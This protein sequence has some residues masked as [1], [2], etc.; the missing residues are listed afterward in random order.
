MG[1]AE[2]YRVLIHFTEFY[3]VLPCS[4]KLTATGHRALNET[5]K[6][7]TSATV[8]KFQKTCIIC[9]KK[10]TTRKN[11]VRRGTHRKASERER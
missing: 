11:T 10:N 4:T 3:R 8:N 2:F 1:S 6:E 7:S 5:D 9:C